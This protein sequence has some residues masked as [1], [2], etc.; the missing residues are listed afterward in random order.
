MPYINEVDK[1][2]KYVMLTKESMR[3]K[4]CPRNV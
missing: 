2:I 3:Y 1:Y 4:T